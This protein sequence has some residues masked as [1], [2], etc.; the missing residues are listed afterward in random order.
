MG[1]DSQ[2][3]SAH[4]AVYHMSYVRQDAAP[5]NPAAEQAAAASG[6]GGDVF[7]PNSAAAASAATSGGPEHSPAAAAAEAIP[8]ITFL[9]RLTEGA[10][11]ESFGLNVAQV[12]VGVV[13]VVALGLSRPGCALSLRPVCEPKSPVVLLLPCG[14]CLPP[15]PAI[16]GWPT[17][18]SGATGSSAGKAAQTQAGGRAAAAAIGPF[19]GCC[20][21]CPARPSGTAAAAGTG[22]RD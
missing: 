20:S 1:A 12:G 13:R 21:T 22:G 3:V 5:P 17:R 7:P 9:Y 14:C 2:A 15:P 4:T 19:G 18:V 6:S 16:D 10:A 11:D 8:V